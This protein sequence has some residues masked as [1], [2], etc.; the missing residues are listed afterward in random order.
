[1]LTIPKYKWN[2]TTTNPNQ[3][4]EQLAEGFQKLHK[5]LENFQKEGSGWQLGGIQNL[6]IHRAVYQSLVGS[7]YVKLPTS[8]EKKHAVV[9][10][11]MMMKSAFCGLLLRFFLM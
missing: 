4:S 1:M 7:S 10:I 11:K 8:I 2:F 5:S 3:F 6:K 9:N